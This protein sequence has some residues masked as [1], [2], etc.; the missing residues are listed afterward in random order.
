[1]P[2]LADVL[3][4]FETFLAGPTVS[5]LVGTFAAVSLVGGLAIG[6]IGSIKSF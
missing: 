2:P 6:V 5:S 1:M 3:A 4:G